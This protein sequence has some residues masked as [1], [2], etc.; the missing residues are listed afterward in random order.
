MGILGTKGTVKSNSYLIELEKFFPEI[1]A[2]KLACPMWVP[3][4]ENNMYQSIAGKLIIHD[5]V[6]NILSQDKEID[7]LLLAC[8]HYPIVK[9]V[10]EEYVSPNV[11]VISQGEIVALSLK[12]YLNRHR[13]LNKKLSKNGSTQYFTTENP[14]DFDEKAELFIGKEISAERIL[15]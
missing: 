7:V 1:K 15:L 3:L 12:D 10:I 13:W 9:P 5:D 2:T 4:I 11:Q 8:T 14:S 6:K